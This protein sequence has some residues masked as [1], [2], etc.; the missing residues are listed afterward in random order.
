MSLREADRYAVI[1]QV[2]QRTMAQ[3]DAALWLNISVRQVKR[4]VRAIRQE[5]PSGAV[6]KRWGVPSNRAI[7]QAVR[8]HFVG[9]VQDSYSDLVPLWPASTCGHTTVTRAVPP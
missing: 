1:Q 9:L 4:L 8:D 2:I 6:S 3:G 5:G 7:P